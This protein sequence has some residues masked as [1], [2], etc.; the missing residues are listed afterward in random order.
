MIYEKL[1]NKF[2]NKNKNKN[3]SEAEIQIQDFLNGYKKA[4]IKYYEFF[5]DTDDRTCKKCASL[6]GKKFKINNA[7]IGVNAPPMHNGCRCCI[8]A[9]IDD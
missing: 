7:K 2:N 6:D 9:V 1:F 8:L 4:G 5:A 3:K